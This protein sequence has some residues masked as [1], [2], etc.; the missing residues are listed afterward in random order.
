MFTDPTIVATLNAHVLFWPSPL[1]IQLPI[2]TFA[3]ARSLLTTDAVLQG[4]L[5]VLAQPTHFSQYQCGFVTGTASRRLKLC[6]SSVC[7]IPVVCLRWS[8]FL[9][10]GAPL[11]QIAAV[12]GA[13]AHLSFLTTKQISVA[14][15]HLVIYCIFVTA[16]CNRLAVSV[17]SLGGSCHDTQVF[18]S[19]Y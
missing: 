6:S 5:Q 15:S 11:W 8:W 18:V 16:L 10:T 14:L 4:A 7:T 12:T 17:L 3:A 13:L 19:F 9:M 2:D 1:P